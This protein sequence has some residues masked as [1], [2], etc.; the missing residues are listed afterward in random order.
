MVAS[1][2]GLLPG[3]L[4]GCASKPAARADITHQSSG[5]ALVREAIEVIRSRALGA[6][7]IEW[8]MA[9]QELLRALPAE[10]TA[11]QARPTVVEAVRR[12]N[13]PHASVNLAPE[14]PPALPRPAA[15]ENAAAEPTPGE[16]VPPRTPPIPTRAGATVLEDGTT[17]LVIPGCAEPTVEGLRDYAA[18][19]R[20]EL[21]AAAEHTPRGLVIDLRLNGG[22][23]IWP[24]LLGLQPMLGE[25]V[26]MTSIGPQ[27]PP[28]IFGLSQRDAWIDWGA[29][30][31]S[32]LEFGATA[33][34]PA[35]ARFHRVA[36]L[37]GPWTMSSGEALTICL[38]TL[39][40]VRV[41]GE[42]TAG[43][44]TV[45]NFFP[46]SDGSVLVLP[47]SVMG[48]RAGVPAAGELAPDEAVPFDDWPGPDDPAAR[49]G[50]AWV[51][52]AGR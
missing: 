22:G 35:R 6:G 30:P 7:R 17:Y 48:D 33:P 24:M 1:I 19:L 39:P 18:V 12:L 25:G 10:A 27:S 38:R 50:R 16:A 34:P 21:L 43:L 14:A 40:E 44:T 28:A 49:A 20:T 45:T 9:E 5:A 23:N 41:F 8:E 42:K 29:G 4:G 13:D 46:L 26:M 11:S 52:R 51:L 32:Q 47:V 31:E 36:V 37:T 2:C 3:S 15:G